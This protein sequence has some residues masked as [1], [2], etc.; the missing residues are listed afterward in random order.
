[1][2]ALS[3]AA[4]YSIQSYYSLRHCGQQFYGLWGATSILLIPALLFALG[5]RPRSTVGACIAITP[6]IVWANDAECVALYQGGGAAMAYVVVFI[7]GIPASLIVGAV[8]PQAERKH[9]VA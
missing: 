9:N 5:G 6:F 3:V 8:I 7:F 4:V 2:A 1:M